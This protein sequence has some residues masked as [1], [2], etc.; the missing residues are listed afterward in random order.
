[1]DSLQ[2]KLKTLQSAIDQEKAA[3]VQ[4][5]VFILGDVLLFEHV[6]FIIVG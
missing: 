3:F 6:I 2:D 5:K 1:M 4:A